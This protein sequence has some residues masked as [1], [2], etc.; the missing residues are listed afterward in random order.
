MKHLYAVFPAQNA[1]DLDS[2]A[3]GFAKE[4]RERGVTVKF[5]KPIG[6]APSPVPYAEAGRFLAASDSQVLMERVVELCQAAGKDCDALVVE[7]V[8]CEEIFFAKELNR[9]MASAL[10]AEVVLVAEGGRD[11]A[12]V[13][14]QAVQIE[15]AFHREAGAAVVGCVVDKIPPGERELF[16]TAFA[17]RGVSV[18]AYIESDADTAESELLDE[19]HWS[20]M[21]AG[22][23]EH[24]TSPPEFRSSLIHRARALDKRIVLPEGNEPRT[25]R[26]AIIVHQRQIARPVLLGRRAEIEAVAEGFGLTFPPEIEVIDPAT[27]VEQFVP[28]LVELRK[29]KGLTPEH[30]RELLQ[31]H[32]WV[33]T[34]MLKEG[35]VDGLVSGA[36]HSTANTISPAFQIIKTAPGSP[37]VSSVFFMCLPTQVLVYGDCAVNPDPTAEELAS[38]AIQSADSARAFGITARV[39]MLSYSTGESGHGADVD[40]VRQA[41]ERVRALR[42]DIAVDGPLQYDAAA[43]E[44]VAKNKA[45][46][47]KIAGHATVF[48]FPDL[49]TGNI[50]YKA[51]QRSARAV[52]VGPMLQGLARPVND[53]SRGALVEDIVYTIALTAIQAGQ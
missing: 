22:E 51:V 43:V 48:V 36:V 34:L 24:R 40:K 46:Q 32:V 33:G 49:N 23:R 44:S 13:V 39:A 27:L 10:D 53:L 45:P 52:S 37:L 14:A 17:G 19:K 47:S 38:I 31:D 21:L 25:V 28:V 41:T 9:L 42:P 50:T 6:P 18:F 3:Q 30:A 26:A 11:S 20:A 1:I 2:V 15:A 5:F 35:L 4:L 16:R 7:G 8:A 29:K 12:S